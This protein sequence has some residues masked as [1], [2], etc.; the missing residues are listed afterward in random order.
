MR[1]RATT[2]EQAALRLEIADAGLRRTAA[3]CHREGVPL[4]AIADVLE[5]SHV[6]VRKWIASVPEA[7]V[8]RFAK[9]DALNS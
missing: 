4:R 1:R 9:L 5:V 3:R 8:D 6:T 7:D 2:R